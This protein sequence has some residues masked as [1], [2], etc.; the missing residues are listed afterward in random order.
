M[1]GQTLANLKWSSSF[2]LTGHGCHST[3]CVTV[4]W[5]SVD[6]TFEGLGSITDENKNEIAS[7][8]HA[9]NHPRNFFPLAP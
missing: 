4:S 9:L 7:P 2:A 3:G 1:K 6:L 8:K 5:I